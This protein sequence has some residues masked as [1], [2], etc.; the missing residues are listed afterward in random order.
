LE[1]STPEPSTWALLLAVMGVL[2]AMR[3]RQLAS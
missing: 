1:F 3:R 2:V